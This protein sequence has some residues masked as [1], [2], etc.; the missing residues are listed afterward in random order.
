MSAPTQ[1]SIINLSLSHVAA[2]P[3][4]SLVEVT[5]QCQAALRAWDFTLKETLR[6]Y[7]WGFA[8]TQVALAEV[9]TYT[10]LIYEYA[11]A[12]PAQCVAVRLVFNA[13]TLDQDVG[14]KFE[15]LYDPTT[16]Q[17]IIVTDCETAYAE[18]T[19]L[20]AD[21]TK[22][23]SFFI[24]TLSHRLAAELAMPLSGDKDMAKDQLTIFNTLCSEAHRHS[25]YESNKAHESNEKSDIVDSRG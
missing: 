10:P 25:S 1:V 2:K 8:K 3:I 13:G 21:V 5:V 6:G 22:F 24:T 4:Q 7:N 14:E 20:V 18:Y 11:Y 17:N 16:N 12:M 9:A 23:D 19:Y 15:V